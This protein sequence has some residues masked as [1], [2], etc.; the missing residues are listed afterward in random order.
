MPFAF[1]DFAWTAYLV[2]IVTLLIGV[3]VLIRLMLAATRALNAYT[4]DRKLRTALILDGDP[5]VEDSRI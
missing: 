3:V 5:S 4:E 1:V 2:V